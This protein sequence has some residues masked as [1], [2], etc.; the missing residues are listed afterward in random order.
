MRA[1]QQIS[2]FDD[3]YFEVRHARACRVIIVN[4]FNFILITTLV[5]EVDRPPTLSF[6]EAVSASR[7]TTFF[8]ACTF[9]AAHIESAKFEGGD[10]GATSVDMGCCC[11][12]YL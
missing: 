5:K 3:P 7:I 12:Y 2:F 8:P 9:A 6:C 11:H 1:E 4:V 10:V